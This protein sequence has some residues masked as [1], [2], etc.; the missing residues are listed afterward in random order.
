MPLVIPAPLR[1]V[2]RKLLRKTGLTR[3]NKRDIA[4]FLSIHKIDLVIDVGANQGQFALDLRERDYRGR[5][6]SFEPVA[7]VYE[8]LS[9]TADADPLWTVSR[10]ALGSTAGEVKINVSALSQYSSI[11]KTSE[12]AA[13]FDQRSSAVATEMVPL[14][15][16]DNILTGETA[17]RIFL[18]IDTQ[19]YEQ[20]VLGGATELLR[21]VEG[22]Q[23]ELPVDHLY[24]NVWSFSQAIN[25]MEE[26]GFVPAQFLAVNPTVNDLA[27]AVEFDAIFRRR[28]ERPS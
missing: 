5:I 17:T 2:A 1:P 18:K 27:S 19:G 20:E 6:W 8:R 7:S 9:A 12:F 25:H 22:V 16:L 3:V 13:R 4:M 28:R 23:M 26:L 10:F 11:K 14:E 24:E 15:T 21:R